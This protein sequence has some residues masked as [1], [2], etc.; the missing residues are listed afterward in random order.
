MPDDA[1]S[2]SP[3][4]IGVDVGGT[5]VKIGVVDSGCN[6]ICEG[7]F[8]TE[9]AKGP[10]YALDRAALEVG[11][12]LHSTGRSIDDAVACGL[13]TPGPMDIQALSLIHI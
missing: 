13:G 5:N 6:V 4:F 10:Q 3:L 8:P 12:L 11:K 1:S 9:Q 7:H 2:T